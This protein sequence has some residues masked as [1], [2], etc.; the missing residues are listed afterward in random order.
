MNI[1]KQIVLDEKDYDELVNCAN[2]SND[3]IKKQNRQRSNY[4]Y[5]I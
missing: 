3:E 4:R 2:L 5:G 1:K